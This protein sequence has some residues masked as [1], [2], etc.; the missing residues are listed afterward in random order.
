MGAMDAISAEADARSD[1]RGTACYIDKAARLRGLTAV[2]NGDSVGLGRDV[3]V[4]TGS[5][6]EGEIGNSSL[7][8]YEVEKGRF[9]FA[10]ERLTIDC[11]GTS[12]THIDALNHVGID[13]SFHAAVPARADDREQAGVSVWSGEGIIARAILANIPGLRGEPWV[14]ADKP[15]TAEEVENCLFL[16][17]VQ[18]CPGDALLLYMGRDRYEAAGHGYDLITPQAPTRPG[19]AGEVGDWVVEHHVSVLCWDFL[20]ASSVSPQASVHARIAS[21]GLVLVDNCALE[22]AVDLF[23]QKS[24]AEGML[25]ISPPALVGSTGMLVNPLLIT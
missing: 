5:H 13:G 4:E 20:D 24:R 10:G 25:C 9:T 23:A 17:N 7:D 2:E 11:H 18:V 1:P 16:D 12:N 6:G 14:T 22:R 21:H 19:A 15:V 3:S 8:Y